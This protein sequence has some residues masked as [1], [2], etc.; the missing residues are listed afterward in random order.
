M[1][2]TTPAI[3]PE[4]KLAPDANAIPKHNGS[5]TSV[6]TIDAG[7][8]LPADFK[9]EVMKSVKKSQKSMISRLVYILKL[10]GGITISGK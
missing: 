2:P 1:P 6:T 10:G 5:A 3:I 8:S 7:K 9:Y 4:N